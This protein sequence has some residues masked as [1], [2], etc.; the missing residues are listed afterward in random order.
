MPSP[1]AAGTTRRRCRSA[2]RSAP[3]AY[4]N[5]TIYWVSGYNGNADAF[6]ITP[7]ARSSPTSQT[8]RRQLRL[9]ARVAV[10]SANG[11]NN[12]IVWVMD[13]NANQLHAYDATLLS[14]EL[15]NSGQKAGG[16]DNLGAVVKFAVPTVAN[17]EVFVGTT[18]SL[19]VYGL[20]PPANAVP[21]AP[22]LTATALSGSS[23]NLTWTDPPRRPTRP[24]ATPS[25]N[26]PTAPPSPRSPPPRPARPRI[27]VGGLTP[28][29]TYYFR[30]R[31]FNGVG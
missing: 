3:P 31:G 23:V 7:T 28:P 4:F 16:A 21:A 27:A 18:N 20:T 30:I 6:T 17:G 24:P 19:V 25:R 29:T 13:R 14:T 22:V 26:R 5:G 11:T 2:A 12:G 15:W 8:S 10:V 1:T 9:P